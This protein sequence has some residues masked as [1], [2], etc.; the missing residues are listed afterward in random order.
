MISKHDI[1]N[2]VKHVHRRDRGIPDRRAM[3]PRREWLI[4]LLVFLIVTAGGVAYSMATFET[5]KNI[6]QRTYTVNVSIPQY[7]EV[8][9]EAVLTYFA[10]RQAHYQEL[11]DQI[12]SVPAALSEQIATTSSSTATTLTTESVSVPESTTTLN[13]EL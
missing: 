13:S 9:A 3:H 6:D 10:E 2:F 5:Y 7:N 12:E 4:G 1:L 11:V 8:R